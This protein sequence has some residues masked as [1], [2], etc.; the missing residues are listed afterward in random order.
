MRNV[1]YEVYDAVIDR[2]HFLVSN[3]VSQG[4]WNIPLVHLYLPNDGMP[5]IVQAAIKA[6]IL[7]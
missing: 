4:V 7:G 3:Q 1:M 2:S 5:S 6:E